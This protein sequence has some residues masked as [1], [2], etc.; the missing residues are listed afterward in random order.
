MRGRILR[1]TC[2]IRPVGRVRLGT[3][4]RRGKDLAPIHGN[5]IQPVEARTVATVAVRAQVRS[6]SQAYTPTVSAAT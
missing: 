3:A 1:S 5:P 4:L 2:A 6:T